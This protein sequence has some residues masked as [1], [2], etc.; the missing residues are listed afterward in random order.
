[1]DSLKWLIVRSGAA[2]P[3]NLAV[4][5]AAIF[6]AYGVNAFTTIY[7]MPGRPVHSPALWGSFVS[8][9]VAAG[10][11]TALAAKKDSIDKAALSGV[12]NHDER[13]AE[14][15]R[16]WQEVWL[17]TLIY[18]GGAAAFSITAL[19]VLVFP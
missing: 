5:A 18:L 16:M 7:A 9:V 19:V 13:E 15:L 6:L 11:W 1:M 4:F 10:L 2:I 14:R 17:R 3:S 12:G 8:S